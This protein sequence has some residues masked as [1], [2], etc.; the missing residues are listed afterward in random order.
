MKLLLYLSENIR[1][2]R[3]RKDVFLKNVCSKMGKCDFFSYHLSIVM[4]LFI[5]D[6]NL[7]IRSIMILVT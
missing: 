6:V 4:V 5:N 1:G 3:E 2:A 7:I